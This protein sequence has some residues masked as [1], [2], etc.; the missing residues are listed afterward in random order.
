[1]HGT[2]RVTRVLVCN[3]DIDLSDLRDLI[4]AWQSRC[5]PA[6]GH[7]VIDNQPAN[8][9]EPMY[10]FKEAKAAGAPVSKLIVAGPV[11]VLNCLLPVGRDFESSDFAHNIPKEIQKR[12]LEHWDE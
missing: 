7:F 1:M 3:D 9:V 10:D 2:Q 12:V 11:E 6:N 4:W 8:P 5:H